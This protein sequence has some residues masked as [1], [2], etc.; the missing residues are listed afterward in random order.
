MNQYKVETIGEVYGKSIM[1]VSAHTPFD[2]AEKTTKYMGWRQKE[3]IQEQEV[4][5]LDGTQQTWTFCKHIDN[6]T[7]NIPG[8]DETITVCHNCGYEN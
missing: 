2:A 6:E 8:T 5:I 3:D 4:K 1:C 7:I